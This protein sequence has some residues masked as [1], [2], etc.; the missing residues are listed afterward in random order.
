MND[1]PP[2]RIYAGTKYWK[3]RFA[4]ELNATFCLAKD[5]PGPAEIAVAS[6]Q[7][8]NLKAS[9]LWRGL[10]FFITVGNLFDATY[11]ARADPDAMFEP[12]RN[13]RVGFGY[14]F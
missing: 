8:V 13:L 1:V 4:A 7:L 5:D 3:G 9:Y 10:D 2:Y 6:S 14:S 11:I 12:A